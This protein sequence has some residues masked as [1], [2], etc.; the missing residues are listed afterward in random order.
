MDFSGVVEEIGEVNGDA[1]VDL[2]Q[3]DEVYGQASI[4]SGGSG[5]FAELAMANK[6]SIA[7]KPKTLNHIELQVYRLLVLVHG[8]HL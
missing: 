5:A 4:S 7:H 3:G 8:K 1:P 6:D 2:K